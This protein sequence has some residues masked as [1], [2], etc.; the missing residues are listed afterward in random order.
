MGA[1]KRLGFFLGWGRP[2]QPAYA[3]ARR[4]RRIPRRGCWARRLGRDPVACCCVHRADRGHPFGSLRHL[5]PND[6]CSLLVRF[7]FAPRSVSSRSVVAAHSLRD[8]WQ[9][10]G[11]RSRVGLRSL[12]AIFDPLCGQFGARF[13]PKSRGRA[14]SVRANTG[15]QDECRDRRC[16]AKFTNVS[17]PSRLVPSVGS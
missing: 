14:A 3:S 4:C 15:L 16:A 6:M 2:G 8:H 11:S 5:A 7:S 12:G 1:E 17:R 13:R 10:T 9:S